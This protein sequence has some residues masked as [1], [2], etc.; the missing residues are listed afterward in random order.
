MFE[1][2]YTELCS[3]SSWRIFELLCTELCTLSGWRIFELLYTELCTLSSWNEE[4]DL[5]LGGEWPDLEDCLSQLG[6]RLV[7]LFS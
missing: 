3:L 7:H 5:V 6:I 1:L 4:V 2:L